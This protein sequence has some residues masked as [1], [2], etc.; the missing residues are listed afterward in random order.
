VVVLS[1][2]KDDKARS[3][4]DASHELGHLLLHHDAEP[5][6]RVIENQAQDFAAAFLTPAE[7]IIDD[8]P[9]HLDWKMFHAAKRRW[10]VSLRALVYRAHSLGVISD[11]AYRRGNITL[12]RWGT[13][14]PGPLGPPESPSV[15]GL[16]A[17]LLADNGTSVDD[18][19]AHASMPREYV[20]AVIAAGTDM[21]PRIQP[22]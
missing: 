12:A 11:S 22:A 7:Q 16:A 4:F 2:A 8:L 10:G 13:P 15:L 21:R 5:G 3:R 1:P 20:D 6:S 9:R 14:E 17:S 18:I 19:A